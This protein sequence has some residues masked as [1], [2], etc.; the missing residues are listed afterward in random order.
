[1]VKEADK[2]HLSYHL[3]SI[4]ISLLYEKCSA[5][6]T[7]LPNGGLEYCTADKDIYQ[8]KLSTRLK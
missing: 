2:Q 1:M 4:I 6:V 8:T 5:Y 7:L 3:C